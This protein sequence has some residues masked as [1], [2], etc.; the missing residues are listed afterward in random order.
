MTPSRG[1][2]VDW[3]LLA[4]LALA[5][6]A[7]ALTFRGPRR[8]FWQRMTATGLALGTLSLAAQPELRRTRLRPG[9]VALGTV[10][11]AALY[12]VFSAAD[13]I[14]RR[15]A[16]GAGGQIAEIYALRSLQS[17]LEIA[18]RLVL[19]IAPAEELF[20]RGFVQP[21]LAA[22]AGTPMG[23]LGAAGLYAG[24]HLI[25]GNLMLIGAAATAGAMWSALAGLG[26]PLGALI[27]SH[28]IWDVWIFL[29]A[30]TSRDWGDAEVQ[31][32][33]TRAA[34]SVAS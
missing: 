33:P 24:A 4:A 1:R 7:F 27:A 23:T 12:V 31:A 19:I 30:P 16:P 26:A 17:R 25:T 2:N 9:E 10:S 6:T 28:A 32:E 8:H 21:R 15:L 3:I 18:A 5:Y 29:L 14:A 34:A 11:A 20:W 22:A 13:R